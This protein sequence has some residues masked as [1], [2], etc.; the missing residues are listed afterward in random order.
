MKFVTLDKQIS[1]T[2]IIMFLNTIIMFYDYIVQGTI[3]THSLWWLGIVVPIYVPIRIYCILRFKPSED[4][5]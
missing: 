1:G 4:E 3:K 5:S 2:D